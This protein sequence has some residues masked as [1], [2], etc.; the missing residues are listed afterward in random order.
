MD[1][2][3]SRVKDADLLMWMNEALVSSPV[4]C[5]T[6]CRSVVQVSKNIQSATFYLVQTHVD[7]AR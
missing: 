5:F 4:C 3:E 2:R 7:A 6:L 1:Q